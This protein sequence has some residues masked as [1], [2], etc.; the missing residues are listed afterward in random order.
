LERLTN[1][2][3][4]LA[5]HAGRDLQ[6][7][8]RKHVT[9]VLLALARFRFAGLRVRNDLYDD[10]HEKKLRLAMGEYFEKLQ[11]AGTVDN[12]LAG[13]SHSPKAQRGATSS[14]AKPPQFRQMPGG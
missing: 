14:A 2:Q 13:T 4:K 12:Y 11:E 3:P 6:R 10:L 7:V 5:S 9:T 1:L 8:G